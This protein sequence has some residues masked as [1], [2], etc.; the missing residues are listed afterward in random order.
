MVVPQEMEY[1]MDKEQSKLVLQGHTPLLGFP[2]GC[3]CR[4]DDIPQEERV[5]ITLFLPLHRE[6]E[7][8]SG[9][10]AR[11]VFT[12]ELLHIVIIKEQNAQF[13]LMTPQAA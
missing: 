8:I 9:A 1:P 12:I 7:D 10:I 2:L 4:Y 6:G 3:F 11:E 5:Q 13:M